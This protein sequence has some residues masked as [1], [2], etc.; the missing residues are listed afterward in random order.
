[1]ILAITSRCNLCCRYCYQEA[2][3]DGEDMTDEILDNALSLIAGQNAPCHVQITGGEPTL[4]PD[5]IAR[6]GDRCRAMAGAPTLA[7]QT[8]GTLLTP[9]LVRLFQKYAIQVGVSLDGPPDIQEEIRGKAADTLRGLKLL[10]DYDI[11][12]RVTTVVTKQN[13]LHLDKLALLLAGFVNSRGI[14]LDLLIDKGRA[15]LGEVQPPSHENLQKGMR[16][17]ITTLAMVNRRRRIPIRLRE[18]DLLG[19]RSTNHPF[20]RAAT[21]Q[22]LAVHPIGTLFPCGQTMNDPAFSMGTIMEPDIPNNVP[23]TTIRLTSH[24]CRTCPLNGRCP[25]DC[26]SR[27]YYNTDQNVPLVCTMY[28]ALVK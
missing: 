13:I 12:F 14:G 20:C 5:R 17:L 1:M 7:I 23:L 24:R 4:L 19:R 25:G 2:G 16:Q 10:E 6:I 22:S 21:G 26:P 27:T 8:N 9:E 3:R 18:V 28:K 15:T 11:P